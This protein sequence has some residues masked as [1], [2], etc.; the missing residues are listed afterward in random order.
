M[1]AIIDLRLGRSLGNAM[2]VESSS[3]PLLR[4]R[5][6]TLAA[7]LVAAVF[8]VLVTTVVLGASTQLLLVVA[9]WAVALRQLWYVDRRFALN[10]RDFGAVWGMWVRAA[11]PFAVAAA[12]VPA[13]NGAY[14][15]IALTA[16]AGATHVSRFVLARQLVRDRKAGL[17]QLPVVACGSHAELMAL[18]DV[19]SR[20]P[21]PAWNV[22]SFRVA[23]H[24]QTAPDREDVETDEHRVVPGLGAAVDEALHLGLDDVILVGSTGLSSTELRTTIWRAQALGINVHLVPSAAPFAAP[25]VQNFGRFGLSQLTYGGNARP[26][27][28]RMV[29]SLLD[30]VLAALGLV[31]ISPLML[32]IAVAVRSTSP[33]PVL[34]RQERVGRDGEL[35]TMLKFRTMV[36]DAEE[37]L[38]QIAEL[39]VH[40]SQTLF[41]AVNDPRVTRVGHF[42]RRF[43]LDELPQ[44]INVVRGDMS[45]VGPRP[46]LPREVENYDSVARRRFLVRPGLTGL[47]Q[48]SGRSDLD[49]IESVRLDTLYVENW[50]LGLDV[51]IL[52]RTARAVL[53][54]DGA[55]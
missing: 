9:L 48:V 28:N 17:A 21:A 5:R 23:D 2:P 38:D 20:D 55:Y 15:L 31:V 14:G 46:P 43:S 8:A 6:Q 13:L 11:L 51:R 26:V 16:L 34:F 24:T 53:S 49:P 12:F 52:A 35:F 1:A 45:L 19:L 29:K 33:G 42:L 41:K 7:D 25:T 30:R 54:S 32:A 10:P 22:A 36:V 40:D 47:W 3:N 27:E 4:L 50:S 44:L 18:E 37:K 39:N